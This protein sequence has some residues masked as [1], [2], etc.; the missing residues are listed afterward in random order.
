M[1]DTMEP[2]EII[3]KIKEEESDAQRVIEEAGAKASS[4]IQE[5]KLTKRK[6]ILR[7]AEDEANSEVLKLK[8]EFQRKTEDCVKQIDA[9]ARKMLEKIKDTAAKNKDMARDYIFNEFLKLWQ[10]QK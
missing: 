4:L 3:N 1:R 8:K 10:L 2:L 5:S 9:D 6:E 7:R